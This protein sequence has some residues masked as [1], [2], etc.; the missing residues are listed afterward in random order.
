MIERV[1]INKAFI[2]YYLKVFLVFFLWSVLIRK[3]PTDS[4]FCQTVF[5][6]TNCHAPKEASDEHMKMPTV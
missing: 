3:Q 6:Y 1:N 5:M 2:L 4:S